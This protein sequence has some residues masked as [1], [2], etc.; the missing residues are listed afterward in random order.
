MRIIANRLLSVQT[1]TTQKFFAVE[2]AL[3]LLAKS[4]TDLTTIATLLNSEKTE[5]AIVKKTGR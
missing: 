1:I 4:A 5:Y 3:F 2:T